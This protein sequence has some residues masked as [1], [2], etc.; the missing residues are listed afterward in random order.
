MRVIASSAALVALLAGPSLA[1]ATPSAEALGLRLLTWPG[2]TAPQGRSRQSSE[3]AEPAP[4]AAT[5]PPPAALPTSIYASSPASAPRPMTTAVAQAQ[6]PSQPRAQAQAAGSD[7]TTPRFYSL[8]RAYGQ[9]PDP[10]P[11]SQQFF[12]TPTED[13][14]EP[15]A[16]PPRTVATANGQVVRTTTNADMSVG[17]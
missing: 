13:L 1:S 4:A 6:A 9:Q 12:S 2:K 10:I 16:L 15:P 17:N 14:A 8:H 11:L 3:R 5:S 7:Y